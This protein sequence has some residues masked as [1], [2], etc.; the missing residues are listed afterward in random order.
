MT[1]PRQA[2]LDA[3]RRRDARARIAARDRMR[4]CGTEAFLASRDRLEGIEEDLPDPVAGR[5]VAHLRRRF[6]PAT[7]RRGGGAGRPARRG[8]VD[9]PRG[10]GRPA[11]GLP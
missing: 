7:E 9:G 1:P 10:A 11:G 4:F 3:N 8:G 2:A 5:R 6:G